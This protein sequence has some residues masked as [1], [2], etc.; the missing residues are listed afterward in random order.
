[1]R[2]P[3]KKTSSEDLKTWPSTKLT[4]NV[5]AQIRTD[6]GGKNP[7]DVIGPKIDAIVNAEPEARAALIHMVNELMVDVAY[8]SRKRVKS[9]LVEIDRRLAILDKAQNAA[10]S[11]SKPKTNSRLLVT[12]K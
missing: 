10:K 7:A 3:G 4:G 1:M 11:K 2:A 8:G 12:A 6:Y 9:K 5:S